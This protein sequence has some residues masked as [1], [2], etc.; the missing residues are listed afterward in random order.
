ME[1]LP[2]RGAEKASAVLGVI[3][4]RLLAGAQYVSQSMLT[5]N[6]DR[7]RAWQQ[8][9]W[10]RSH[11]HLLTAN[12][13]QIQTRPSQKTGAFNPAVRPRYLSS[14]ILIHSTRTVPFWKARFGAECV[15]AVVQGTLTS[16]A[17]KY[18]I[19]LDLDRKV[20]DMEMP[21]YAQQAQTLNLGS[22]MDGANLGLGLGET[23]SRFMPINY[24]ELS[25]CVPH[26]YLVQKELIMRCIHIAL[27]YI[28]RCFFA[29]AIST[30]PNDPIKSAYA[31]SFLAGYRS[32]CTILGSVRQ[33]FTLF[34][35]QIA[36]FWVLWTHAFSAAVSCF[37]LFFFPF[38]L[39]FFSSFF[40]CISLLPALFPS[41]LKS[42]SPHSHPPSLPPYPLH[43]P[44]SFLS[45]LLSFFLSFSSFPA[46]FSFPR[47]CGYFQLASYFEPLSDACGPGYLF[48]GHVSVS[49]DTCVQAITSCTRGADR[50]Q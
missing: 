45:C 33:Q 48:V 14:H 41:S 10:P 50:T 29:H 43:S 32:A 19:I 9:G 16:R 34:P 2:R 7:C 28:H 15:S 37:S 6:R 46:L 47:Y 21:L 4:Y 1:T 27:L 26:S 36:R 25:A 31:P 20:R 49:G 18:S 39:F 40:F 38:P 42:S 35:R 24:R 12:C 5:A 13:P 11:F 3:Y 44:F 8:A 22:N 17:P 23:M 30:H